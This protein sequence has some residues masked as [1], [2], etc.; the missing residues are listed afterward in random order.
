MYREFLVKHGVHQVVK[1]KGNAFGDKV[2]YPGFHAVDP[3]TY[4]VVECRFLFKVGN[5]VAVRF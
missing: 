4:P 1:S 3:H 5:A 2:E